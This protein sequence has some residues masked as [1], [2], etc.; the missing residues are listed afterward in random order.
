ML[1]WVVHAEEAP[2]IE[3]YSVGVDEFE[4]AITLVRPLLSAEGKLI[5][6][7]GHHRLLVQDQPAVL[8]RIGMILQ[9]WTQPPR[10]IRI[11]V[12]S[13]APQRATDQGFGVTGRG[14]VPVGGG[15]VE[16][17]T[18]GARNGIQVRGRTT[19]V[20]SDFANQQELLVVSGGKAS[21][22]IAEEVPEAAWF[23]DWGRQFSYW[24]PDVKWRDVGTKM[25]IE[26]VAVSD[27]LIRVKLIP[28]FSYVVDTKA[29]AVEVQQV[30]TEVNVANGAEIDIG[31]LKS[32]QQEFMQKFLL[33]RD[34]SGNSRH[35]RLLLRATIEDLP[36]R[37]RYQ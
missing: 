29:F 19:T 7:R 13:L 15:A 20:Q 5:E 6:D 16:V 27:H 1:A 11:R 2:Q 37:P 18:P 23:L 3:A 10:N 17:G 8:R 21:I 22:I 25:T 30:A 28:T 9:P 35:V 12:R 26:P 14:R 32:S 24:P 34:S 4:A 31:G 36:P 33:S